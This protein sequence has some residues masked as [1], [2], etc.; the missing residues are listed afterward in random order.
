MEDI[1]KQTGKT[2]AIRQPPQYMNVHISGT[3]LIVL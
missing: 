3:V 2:I 1:L